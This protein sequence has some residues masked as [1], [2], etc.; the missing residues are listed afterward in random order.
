[1]LEVVV[2]CSAGDV[3]GGRAEG[4]FGGLVLDGR[5]VVLG[6]VPDVLGRVVVGR[7]RRRMDRCDALQ[8]LTRFVEAGQGSGVVEAGV[9]QDGRGLAGAGFSLEQVRCEDRLPG[10]PVPL[11][12]VRRDCSAGRG[13]G[14]GERLGRLLP[15]HGQLGALP[16][17]EPHAAGLG[18]VLQADLVC[19]VDLPALVQQA[20]DLG[21]HLGHASGGGF[22]VAVLAERVRAVRGSARRTAGA[23]GTKNLTRTRH[24][25][26]SSRRHVSLGRP[27]TRHQS[28]TVRAAGPGWS[29]VLASGCG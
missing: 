21:L 13:E 16:S 6:R 8:Q 25:T 28:R 23:A 12:R 18:L 19:R 10:V 11:G 29:R 27:R 7:V 9:V 15:V 2:E 26:G 4:F 5:D 20:F 17:G 22:L 24:R 1:M 14:A 3:W